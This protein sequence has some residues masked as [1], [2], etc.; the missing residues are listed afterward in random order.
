MVDVTYRRKTKID[1][2]QN[3]KPEDVRSCDFK[4]Q[5]QLETD[6][7][8]FP[9]NKD[10]KKMI[11]ELKNNS[12]QFIHTQVLVHIFDLHSGNLTGATIY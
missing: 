5:S 2:D 11:P 10:R 9:V 1:T 6:I 7:K 12:K 3:P 4:F 8:L